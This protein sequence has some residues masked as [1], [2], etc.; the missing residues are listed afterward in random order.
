MRALNNTIGKKK[1]KY[2]EIITLLKGMN[3][4]SSTTRT[5]TFMFHEEQSFNSQLIKKK[6]NKIKVCL[7]IK[8]GSL[9]MTSTGTQSFRL[10]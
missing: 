10:A 1:A 9:Q 7:R 6:D 8:R 2:D 4:I 5:K 3:Q